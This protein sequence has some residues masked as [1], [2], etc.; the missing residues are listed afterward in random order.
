MRT[1]TN[2]F[3][4]HLQVLSEGECLELLNET[5]V[6]RVAWNEPEGPI[7]LP[8]NYTMDGSSV[9]FRTALDGSVARQL[10]LGFASFQIDEHDEFTQT[11][12]SVLVRGVL[13][14]VEARQREIDD[15][16]VMPWAEGDRHFAMRITPL[17]IT[18]RRI[19]PV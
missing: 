7:V 18:G 2:W 5:S 6:G 3:P 9:I 19:I 13:S 1:Q 4:G 16:K 12:W 17:R 10:H 11:G 15:S 8:V 14:C